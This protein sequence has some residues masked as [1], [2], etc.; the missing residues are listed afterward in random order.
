M[1]HTEKYSDNSE[2]VTS[3]WAAAHAA[4]HFALVT[5]CD[6]PWLLRIRDML[7]AH[8]ERYRHFSIP[9]SRGKRNLDKEHRELA[10]AMLRRDEER[11]CT[12]M[13]EHLLRTV[14]FT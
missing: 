4:F 10:D 6:S 3:E 8:S 5:A 9:P 12:M 11:I 14:G 2:Q 1:D 13:R 7:F